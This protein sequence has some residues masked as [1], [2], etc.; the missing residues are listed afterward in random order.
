MIGLTFALHGARRWHGFVQ[1]GHDLHRVALIARAG[2]GQSPTSSGG[3]GAAT[4]AYD[5]DR[6]MAEMPALAQ[7]GGA[8]GEAPDI[9]HFVFD[10]YG[11]EDTLARTSA[12]A[13]RIGPSSNRRASTS[14]AT[15][16]PTTSAPGIRWP[17]PSHMD[18]LDALAADPRVF[19]TTGFRSSR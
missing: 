4:A 15:A 6:A 17:R 7:T 10:R 19:G 1:Y 13:S 9:Y 18:Y 11:S 5:A 8:D 3:N 14:R 16:S 2:L 12:S